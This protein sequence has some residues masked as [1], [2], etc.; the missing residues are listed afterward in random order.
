MGHCIIEHINGFQHFDPPVSGLEKFDLGLAFCD[1]PAP[2]PAG[3]STEP[4]LFVNISI[5]QISPERD[6]GI[7]C[8]CRYRTFLHEGL[9]R[10]GTGS[11]QEDRTATLKSILQRLPLD[12]VLLAEGRLSSSQAVPISV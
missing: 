3:S 8:Y 2:P 7:I 9:R 4:A 12:I 11:S 10:D 5:F 6:L 1:D